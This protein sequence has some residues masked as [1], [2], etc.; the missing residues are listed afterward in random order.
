MNRS[1]MKHETGE[2]FLLA[3]VHRL[4]ALAVILHVLLR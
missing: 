4:G 2:R 3:V 1:A